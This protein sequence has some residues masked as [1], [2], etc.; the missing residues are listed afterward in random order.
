MRKENRFLY[1]LLAIFFLGLIW[2]GWHA[3]DHL[4]WL[5]EV[6]PALLAWLV[7]TLTFK[8]FR[9]SNWL[10]GLMLA[11]SLILMVGGQTTYAEMPLF[12]W[13][14]DYFDLSRNYY[15]RLGH[16]AQGFV[17][18]LALW[19]ITSKKNIFTK[20]GWQFVFIVAAVL[21]AS[22]FYEFIEWWIALLS[23][24]TGNDFLGTQGDIWDTQWDM[25]MCFLGSLIGLIFLRKKIYPLKP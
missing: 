12:N 2:T 7:L 3:Q 13:L 19:E 11:H 24:S 14:K 20:R 9:F 4:I 8:K 15:D 21:G 5:L 17:P 23:P 22:A 10:Y 16:F 6:F 18:A 1:A 25:F